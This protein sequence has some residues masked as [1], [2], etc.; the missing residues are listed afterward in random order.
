MRSSGPGGQ[1]VNK[2]ESAVRAKHLP[3]GITVVA[4]ERRS[5][6]QNKAEALERLQEKV[7]LWHIQ[8][9]ADKAM[10]QWQQHNTLERGN[11]IRTF[12]ERL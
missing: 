2:T 5:Q 9:A 7:S 1:H 8:Q 11:S 6:H 4:S 12:E 3:S 10:D